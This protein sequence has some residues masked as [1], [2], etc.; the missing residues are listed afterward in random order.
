MKR[1]QRRANRSTKQPPQPRLPSGS[2]FHFQHKPVS[3]MPFDPSS[4]FDP[5]DPW[6][7]WQTYILPHLVQ[8]NAPPNAGPGQAPNPTSLPNGSPIPQGA[9]EDDGFPNDW[10]YP[11]GQNAPAPAPPTASPAPTPQSNPAASNQAPARFDP[12]A[13][14][15]AQ[16]PASRVGA[17]AWHPPIFLSP[18]SFAPQ[19]TPSSARGG[20]PARF[21]NPLA[22][23]L[24]AASA[25]PTLPP[26]FGTG[27]ILGG[28]AKLAAEQARAND[29]WQAGP[30]GI[31]GGIAKLAATYAAAYPASR[32]L[33]G[34]LAN[35]QST[36]SNGPTDAQ[37]ALGSQ[38]FLPPNPREAQG[39]SSYAYPR[40]DLP[41]R[42]GS[43]A[44]AP[45]QRPT[46]ETF[47]SALDQH[48]ASPYLRLI[49]GDELWEHSK[50][51]PSVLSGIVDAPLWTPPKWEKPAQLRLPFFLPESDAS[52]RGGAGSNSQ[53]GSSPAQTGEGGSPP[54]SSE[55]DWQIPTEEIKDALAAGGG[56]IPAIISA[57][58]PKYDGETTY[59][60]L[61]T[62]E[63]D[64]VPLRSSKR[65]PP[66]TNYVPSGHVEGK[67]AVWMREH[68]SSGGVVYH[69]NTDGTCGFC[70]SQVGTLLPPGPRLWIV[71]PADAIAK[72]PWARQG[73]TDHV[74]NS[75]EPN[76][77]AQY[78]PFGRKP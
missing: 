78:D 56:G 33:F 34:S 30:G 8:P 14:Y 77:P 52:S 10:I 66:Y 59:G 25:L 76:L 65:T 5:S 50:P 6:Q 20:P 19:N 51:D 28:I 29:P 72:N 74:G 55:P 35:L 57:T 12:Y 37:S 44:L 40:S 73:L 49:N 21:A 27:G 58:L 18:D 53:G 24:P 9:L 17:M 39:G 16:V 7:W 31:L 15:W 38:P 32:G 1:H 43:K 11:D 13:A 23:F 60:I 69:N 62:N 67:A 41:N 26:D 3:Q 71:P 63:G 42:A 75:A 36:D 61:I 2:L 68:G 47:G 22:Q 4:P 54:I 64:V 45:N 46:D 48:N 70:N